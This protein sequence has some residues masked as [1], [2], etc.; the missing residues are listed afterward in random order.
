MRKDLLDSNLEAAASI[1]RAVVQACRYIVRNK[2]ETIQV[3]LK[4]NPGMN[5]TVPGDLRFQRRAVE[6]LGSFAP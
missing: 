5:A 3:V 2:P 6:S 4:C 1:T